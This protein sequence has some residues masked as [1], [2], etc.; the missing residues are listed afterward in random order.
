MN[1]R[2]LIIEDNAANL[3][4]MTYLLRAYGYTPLVAS[5]GDAG[6]RLA[7]DELPD[8]I[9]CDVQLPNISGY[10]IARQ[11]KAAPALRG[12]PLVAVTAFAMV[13]D[14]EKVLAAGFDGYL[15]KPIEPETFVP[16]LEAFLRPELRAS[17]VRHRDAR[18]R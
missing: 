5:E 6:L 4:L 16:E 3:A 9:V 8:L 11:I 15:S 2:I 17:S 13:G 1:T 12:I 14:R 18:E 7:R 10:D